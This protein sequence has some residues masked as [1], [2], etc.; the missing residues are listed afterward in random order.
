MRGQLVFLV[1]AVVALGGMLAGYLFWPLAA[2]GG[3][4]IAFVFCGGIALGSLALVLIHRITGGAWFDPLSPTA[5]PLSLALP[6]L[7]AAFIP[8]IGSLGALYHWQDAREAVKALWLNPLGFSARTLGFLAALSVLAV[9][10][11]RNRSL[12]L[13]GLGICLYVFA[14]HVFSADWILALRRETMYTAFGTF[15]IIS[16]LY[17]AMAFAIL[18]SPR[19]PDSAARDLGG[20]L[21]ALSVGA[22]YMG[23]ADYLVAWYGNV[24]DHIAWYAT[25]AV[26]PWLPLMW[27][28]AMFGF[29]LPAF[30]LL[31]SRTRFMRPHLKLVA[32]SILVGALSYEC[33]LIAPEAGLAAILFAG[34]GILFLGSLAFGFLRAL[35]HTSE[36]H[37]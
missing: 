28:G 11:R 1:T 8:V 4:L 12:L 33:W 26:W 14:V 30:I 25:R 24:P 20:L 37:P 32:V 36:A 3:W 10:M 29:A 6:A 34:I 27:G 31:A 35:R 19:M 17:T 13:P 7:I 2:A 21:V 18:L 9:W 16:Q 5:V 23:G 22:F 15:I